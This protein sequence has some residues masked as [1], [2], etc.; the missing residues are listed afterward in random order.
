MSEGE[1]QD[2]STSGSGWPR[3][4]KISSI[5]GG[6]AVVIGL[7]AD[8]D[9]LIG[10][11]AVAVSLFFLCAGIATCG[12]GAL[13]YGREWG[14]PSGW[15]GTRGVGVF[16]AGVVTVTLSVANLAPDVI[17]RLPGSDP[18]NRGVAWQGTAELTPD[19][20]DLDVTPPTSSG[21]IDIY[22]HDYGIHPR[23]P[24]KL[25]PWNIN[26][27]SAAECSHSVEESVEHVIDFATT[28]TRACVKTSAGKIALVRV[29]DAND[30]TYRVAITL[31][32]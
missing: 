15:R 16:T 29:T 19:G 27:A 13:V 30:S 11:P 32:R 1:S 23:D 12:F 9:S 7:L 5:L 14:K 18:A 31:Y 26:F 22:S 3:G 21:D 25:S 6:I 20:L 8:V 10:I 24:A 28:N 4:L 17:D 2:G